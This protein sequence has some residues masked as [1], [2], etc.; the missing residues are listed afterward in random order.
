MGGQ[1]DFHDKKGNHG[2]ITNYVHWHSKYI[3][4]FQEIGLKIEQCIEPKFEKNHL[5][6]ARSGSELSGITIS[7][8]FQGLPMALIW[9][10]KK[11]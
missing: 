10:L 3:Q 8:A 7:T 6:L 5:R 4:V 2:Y 9:L 11:P 1:A